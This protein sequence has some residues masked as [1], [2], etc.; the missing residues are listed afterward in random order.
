MPGLFAHGITGDANI[1]GRGFQEAFYG[2][3]GA[4]LTGAVGTQQSEYLPR[5]HFEGNIANGLEGAIGYVKTLY[6]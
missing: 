1:A 2:A 4:C 5:E 6:L 3:E